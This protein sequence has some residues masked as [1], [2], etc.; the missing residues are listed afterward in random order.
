M[1]ISQGSQER[2]LTEKEK[3]ARAELNHAVFIAFTGN[4]SRC[5]EGDPSGSHT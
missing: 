2:K 4:Q 5:I 3:I 1:N